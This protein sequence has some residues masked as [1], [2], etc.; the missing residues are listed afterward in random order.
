MKIYD[1]NAWRRGV[2]RIVDEV[3]RSDRGAREEKSYV[4]KSHLLP[5]VS[6]RVLDS[7]DIKRA[8]SFPERGKWDSRD[9]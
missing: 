9:A 4:A 2:L 5:G 3:A 7:D 1:G 8:W 6:E